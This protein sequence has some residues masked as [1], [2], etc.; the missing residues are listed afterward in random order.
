MNTHNP[1]KNIVAIGD[2]H[3][4]T[5]WKDIVSEHPDCR[6]VFLGDYLDP[7]E[8]LSNRHV[9]RNLQ[10]VILLKQQ[11]P[12]EIVL[13]LGNHDLHYF[14][15]EMAVSSRFDLAIA[16]EVS[17]IF[18]NSYDLFQFAFQE[19]G[20]V[21]THAGISQQWF[22]TDFHGDATRNIA[23]QLNHHQPEQLPALF[24][25]GFERGGDRNTH[26]GI[27]WADIH[28]LKTPLRGYTQVVGHNRVP[29]ILDHTANGGRII[30]CDCLANGN[31]LKI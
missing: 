24:R 6:I 14:T 25:C 1:H 8:K 18:I 29:D 5:G 23:E 7:Y 10:D 9:I 27:F 17:E 13:L 22:D 30:F 31:Y 4:L 12:D 3:G 21:F 11:R 26:G 16:A 19:E 28:E 20:C 15:E 2:I